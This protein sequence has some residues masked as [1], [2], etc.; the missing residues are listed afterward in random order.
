VTTYR[1]ADGQTFTY[2]ILESGLPQ[3]NLKSGDA[4][5]VKDTIG[6]VAIAILVILA[7]GVLRGFVI[8]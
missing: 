3:K 2:T 4:R 8:V 1:A 7:G 5:V 6:R